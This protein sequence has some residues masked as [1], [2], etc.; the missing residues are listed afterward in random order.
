MRPAQHALE[1][2]LGW[3]PSLRPSLQTSYRLHSRLSQHDEDAYGGKK[4]R[5]QPALQPGHWSIW[6]NKQGPTLDQQ[7]GR[8]VPATCTNRAN[9]GRVCGMKASQCWHKHP[10]Q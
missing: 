7:I 10:L 8:T 3:T 6:Q 4:Q 1:D 5:Q 2:K 9:C